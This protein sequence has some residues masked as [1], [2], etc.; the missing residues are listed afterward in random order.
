MKNR[1]LAT[2]LCA[3]LCASASAQVGTGT[4]TWE[5]SADGGESWA[6]GLVVVPQDQQEVR[7]RGVAAWSTDAG[8]WGFAGTRFDFVWET[9]GDGDAVTLM[10][11]IPPFN[12]FGQT[13][14]ATRFGSIIKIDDSRDTLP[15]G[16]GDRG[17]AP[18][19][20]AP[21]F[22]N[23]DTSNPIA[24]VEF[25]FA[26]DGTPGDREVT[27]LF[28]APTGGNTVDRVYRV[29]TTREGMQNIP[30]VSI[31]NATVRVVPSPAAACTLLATALLARRRT[32]AGQS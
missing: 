16:E 9:P 11:R 5:V 30:L 23:P 27:S 19:Q 15:P 18:G 12:G 2:L 17:V 10:R 32:R 7:I 21:A 20:L 3:G 4:W 1:N 26:L 25:R 6:S 22:G 8:T 29:Y 31:H 13:L 14:A 24:V 28:M